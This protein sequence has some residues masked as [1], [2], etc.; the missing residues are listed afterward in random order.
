MAPRTNIGAE[1]W[2]FLK[3]LKTIIVVALVSCTLFLKPD[4]K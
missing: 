3:F 1:N 2:N 4:E